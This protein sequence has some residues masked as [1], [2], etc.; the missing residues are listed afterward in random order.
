MCEKEML[1]TALVPWELEGII[2]GGL[3][4]QGPVTCYMC[5]SPTGHPSP[6]WGKKDKKSHPWVISHSLPLCSD[7]PFLL[8]ISG[9]PL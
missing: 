6:Q 1:R 9:C 3:F 2:K 5:D 8:Q 7:C 4:S